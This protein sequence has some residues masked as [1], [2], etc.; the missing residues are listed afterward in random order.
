MDWLK[1]IELLAKGSPQLILSACVVALV[2][3]GWRRETDMKRERTEFKAADSAEREKLMD[4]I[5]QTTAVTT[6]AKTAIN[7]VITVIEH[8]IRKQGQ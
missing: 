4:L 7:K 1:F 6:D 5:E 3:W 2:F 8:C